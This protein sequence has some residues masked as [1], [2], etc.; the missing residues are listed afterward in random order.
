MPAE[1]TSAWLDDFFKHYYRRRP[2]NATFIG[3][4][5]LDG[6]LPDYSADGVAATVGEMRALLDRLELGR[7]EPPR[8][9][10]E[11]IDRLL[12]R[13]YLLMQ[14]WE[15]ESGFFHRRNP[16]V[17]TGEAIFGVIARFVREGIATPDAVTSA[18]ERLNAIPAFL[19]QGGTNIETV[20]R[21]WVERAMR[22]CDGALAFLT[23]GIRVLPVEPGADLKA[24]HA[25]AARAQVAF[26]DFRG[27]LSER[28]L[29]VSDDHYACGRDAF[30]M[31]VSRG[32]CLDMDG[33]AVERYA[34][35][36]FDASLAELQERSARIDATAPWQAVAERVADAHPTASDFNAA[37]LKAW[38][39]ARSVAVERDLVTWPDYPLR[40]HAIPEWARGAAPHLYFLFYRAP[41]PYDPHIEPRY[42]LPPI[43]GSTP[44]A[45]SERVLRAFNDSQIK[46]NHIVHHAGLGHHV[47]NF[48]AYQSKSRVGQIAAV[49]CALRIAMYSAGS[50]CEGWACYATDLME[51]VGY[52]TSL[53]LVAQ[54][55]SRLRMAARAIVDVN[56]HYGV[57]GLEDAVAYYRDAVAMSEPAARSEA[58]KNSMFPGAALMYLIGTDAIHDL[59]DEMRTA[60][61]G[62]LTHRDFH[63]ELLSYGSIP[64][65]LIG[66]AMR[67]DTIVES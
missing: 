49:D 5:E 21:A 33:A 7:V 50:L 55:K 62:S 28:A 32:H 10:F 56:L 11:A 64:V 47:Q 6:E 37:V 8:D 59:R 1:T 39:E 24:F 29:G 41:A 16:C 2:V 3:V 63:S 17:Y 40:F 15:F 54:S 31:L 65:S 67:G 9:T 19:A 53:E 61:G 22:E 20:P 58:V 42:Y 34:R 52:L 44:T 51:E 60:R 43:D 26:G 25:A 45:E 36:Q 4:H 27:W 18:T 57:F 13:N 12:A 38:D 30:D 66:K 23:E 48:N 46:L 35:E 14:V